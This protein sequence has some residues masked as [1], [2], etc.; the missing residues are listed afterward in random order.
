MISIPHRAV[1]SLLRAGIRFASTET[2]SVTITSF[3]PPGTKL[4]GINV[5]KNGQ[6][7]I[8]LP[9]NEYPDWLWRLLDEEAQTKSLEAEPAKLARKQQRA[10][11]RQKIKMN[12]FMA[13]MKK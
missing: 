7:P 6:D 10:A 3:A 4:K 1:G 2:K 9:E 8:A 13:G 11:N 5:K 12:N